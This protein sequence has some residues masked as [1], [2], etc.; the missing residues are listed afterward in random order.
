[1]NPQKRQVILISTMIILLLPASIW[2]YG[3]MID[4]CQSAR[5][6]MDDLATCRDL[7]RSMESLKRSPKVAAIEAMG[8]EELGARIEAALKQA[9]AAGSSLTGVFPQASRRLGDSPYVHKPTVLSLR[10]ISLGQLSA[11]LYHLT[12]DSPLTVRDLRIRAPRD[13]SAQNLW[14]AETTLTYLVYSPPAKSR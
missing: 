5:D 4:Q 13:A 2:S 6:A 3:W 12:E 7:S 9:Q 14:D 11:F 10:G 8:V 1:M